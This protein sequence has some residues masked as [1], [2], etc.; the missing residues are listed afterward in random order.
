MKATGSGSVA[1][2]TCI[3]APAPRASP[4]T[5]GMRASATGTA[6]V[7]AGPADG[8]MAAVRDCAAV[9]PLPMRIEAAQGLLRHAGG[10]VGLQAVGAAGVAVDDHI[11]P[12]V[13]QPDPA[14]GLARHRGDRRRHH[15]HLLVVPLWPEVLG[16]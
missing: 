8:A 5:A 1:V 2:A 13:V 15:L 11:D 4:T 9:R 7:T 6:A 12:G 3:A 10:R 16:F 14:G